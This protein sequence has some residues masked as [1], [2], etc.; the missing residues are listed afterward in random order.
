MKPLF[1]VYSND[2]EPYSTLARRLEENI[3]KFGAGDFQLVKARPPGEDADFF[4]VSA[5]L[6]YSYIIRMINRRPLIVLDCDNELKKPL[7]DD[8]FNGDWDVAAC[9]RKRIILTNGR[10]DYNAGMVALNNKRPD[11]IRKFCVEWINRMELWEKPDIRMCAE[12]LRVD[13]WRPSWYNK[14][15]SLNQIILPECNQGS[16]ESDSYNIIPGQSYVSHGYKIMPL[17]R[18]LYGARPGTKNAFI[19]HYKG[20]KKRVGIT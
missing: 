12:T 14:Q 5:C 15:S 8:M 3:R 13:G 7:P 4:T 19:I 20:G 18:N 2:R 17:A 11:I 9:Y 6:M 1:L 10:Q 16:L